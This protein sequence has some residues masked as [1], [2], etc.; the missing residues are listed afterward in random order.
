VRAAL[1]AVA[2]TAAALVLAPVAPARERAPELWIEAGLAEIAAHRTNPPRA[3]RAL[4]LVSVAMRDAA[5]V[6]P[7]HRQSAVDAAAAVV[8][9][10]LFPDRAARFE[11]LAERAHTRRGRAHGRRAAARVVERARGDGA[12]AIWQG[13]PPSGP[14]L[15]VPT[16]P[17][18]SPPL[19][20][21]VGTWRTWRLGAGS[22]VRPAP[23]PELG[24]VRRAHEVREVYDVSRSLTTGQ[25]QIALR[26][27]DGPGTVTPPGHWNR[28]A[29]RLIRT[30]GL[31]SRAAARVLATMNMA[32]ADAFVACWDAKFRYWSER[33]VT[34]I[35]REI[36]A[37]WL[38][39]IATPPF[40]SYV[41]GHASV[42]GA[43]SAVL[44]AHF[45]GAAR[46]LEAQAREAAASR[47]Y[48][49]IHFRSDNEA[50]LRLGRRVGRTVLDAAS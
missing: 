32:Q 12:D 18:L 19:E 22:R 4:A 21:L 33:P 35:R 1:G 6:A 31:A 36:D 26:W 34:V 10:S 9:T 25:R 23:P 41:S 39:L 5:R 2:A 13:S 43:A 3:A 14:G 29:L 11:R 44:A 50:G 16:P 48:G 38:P 28:I 47:L 8:L 49:G 46:R 42:S 30:R 45:P 37:Q 40:P 24:S 17:S 15:W 20:P 27:A 7:R